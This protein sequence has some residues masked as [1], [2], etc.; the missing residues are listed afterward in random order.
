MFEVAG[1][2]MFH[3]GADLAWFQTGAPVY[4]AADGVVRLSM[5]PHLDAAGE[6]NRGGVPTGW[7][8]MIVIEHR[9]PEGGEFLTL[10]AHL[11]NDRRV[12]AGD[13][14][15]AGQLIGEIGKKSARINGGYEPHLHF[16]IRE[17]TLVPKGAFLFSMP[18]NGRPTQVRLGEIGEETITVQMPEGTPDRWG[19]SLEGIPI[20]VEKTDGRYP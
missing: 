13:V 1:R 2:P 18:M 19:V 17:G 20:D 16:G 10:Y 11:G 12:H 9:L 14:V 3:T 15:C 7:G 8:N 5:P 6:R 4:A